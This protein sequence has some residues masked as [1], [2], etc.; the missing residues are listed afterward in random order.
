MKKYFVAFLSFLFI[1][2]GSK[3]QL[4]LPQSWGSTFVMIPALVVSG[5][6]SISFYLPPAKYHGSVLSSDCSMI[7]FTGRPSG[8]K[9]S[10][11]LL[12][13]TALICYPALSRCI[14]GS[15]GSP[16]FWGNPHILSS[17]MDG[18]GCLVLQTWIF[19]MPFGSISFRPSC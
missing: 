1:L 14:N 5:L 12:S 17:S 4:L 8:S 11:S 16:S 10:R 15:Q 19:L 7:S 13:H 9:R 6:I 3:L 18:I 2:E